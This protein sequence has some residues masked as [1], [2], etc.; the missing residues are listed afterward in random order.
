MMMDNS[1]SILSHQCLHCMTIF[2]SR[3]KLFK[4]LSLCFNDSKRQKDSEE[5]A[6]DEEKEDVSTFDLFIIGGRN[7]GKTL[8]TCE[9]LNLGARSEA[10]EWARVPAYLI[11]NRGSHGTTVLGKKIYAMGGG[12]IKSNLG[13]LEVLNTSKIMNSWK[14]LAPMTVSRH[15]LTAVSTQSGYLF[16]I[17]GTTSGNSGYI[18]SEWA[19]PDKEGN[20][21]CDVVEMYDVNKDEWSLRAPMRH[22][23]RLHGS[24]VSDGK[25]YVFGGCCND[26]VW[27][28]D[29]AEVYDPQIDAWDDLPCM[30]YAGEASA[31][32]TI[33]S[34][35]FVLIHGKGIWLFDPL[36]LLYKNLGP[37]PIVD[38]HCF[39]LT[40]VKHTIFVCGG[41]EAGKV[42]KATYSCDTSNLSTEGGIISWRKEANLAHPG[43]RSSLVSVER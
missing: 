31:V 2:E 39:C 26:P 28:T 34:S 41:M 43:R 42:C 36:R 21:C 4:H 22:A 33:D 15:A 27:F 32:S 16:A 7:R 37:L 19:Q 20:I 30:P 10:Q 23:R 38:W 9:K 35:I 5:V 13:T 25:I 6:K 12:G 17:G 24:C 14:V 40:T 29:K 1:T 3:N 11:N 18:N 8:K